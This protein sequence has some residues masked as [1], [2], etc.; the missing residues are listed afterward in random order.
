VVYLEQTA[1][2]YYIG[3]KLLG[4]QLPV[5]YDHTDIRRLTRSDSTALPLSASR[6]GHG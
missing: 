5:H 1:G 3:G 4:L 2:T 6:L